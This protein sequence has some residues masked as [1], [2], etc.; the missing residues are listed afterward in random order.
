MKKFYSLLLLSV[1][2]LLGFAASAKTITYTTNDTAHT[3]VHDI[4]GTLLTWDASGQIE[5]EWPADASAWSGMSMSIYRAQ[6][7]TDQYIFKTIKVNGDTKMEYVEG[8]YFYPGEYDG[9]VTVEFDVVKKEAVILTVVGDPDQLEVD[10]DYTPIEYDTDNNCWTID[11]SSNQYGY[12]HL[13]PKTGYLIKSV[14]DGKGNNVDYTYGIYAGNFQ[15]STTLTVTTEDENA[16]KTDYV[17]FEVNGDA[18]KVKLQDN[19]YNEYSL[20][21]IKDEPFYYDSDRQVPFT[22]GGANYYDKVFKVTID[23]G[24]VEQQGTRWVVTPQSGATITI[25]VDYPSWT[26]PVKAIF[27]NTAAK[28]FI[29][30]VYVGADTYTVDQLIEGLDLQCG[31]DVRVNFDFSNYNATVSLNGQPLEYDEI[32][33]GYSFTVNEQTGYTFNINATKKPGKQIY[34]NCAQYWDAIEIWYDYSG[35]IKESLTSASNTI[36]TPASADYLYVKAIGDYTITD[37][38]DGSGASYGQ[39]S[40]SIPVTAGMTI[41]VYV[42]KFERNSQMAVYLGEGDWLNAEVYVD[43]YGGNRKTV[44]L[45]QGYNLISVAEGECYQFT[46]TEAV[47]Y[48]AADVYLNG[49]HCAYSYGTYSGLGTAHDGDVIKA[50]T[51]EQ[52][53][54][55]V[56]YTVNTT[57][58]FTVA[59]DHITLVDN[60]ANHVLLP[61]T[62][63]HITPAETDK[64]KVTVNDVPMD[65]VA[66][67]ESYAITADGDKE[68][69][70]ESDAS[71]VENID[72]DNIATDAEVY[73]LQ[74]IRVSNPQRGLYIVNGKKVIL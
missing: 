11:P 70:I 52:D 73:N 43:P 7:D 51:A 31:S 66:E 72:V 45:K 3:L 58:E 39:V 4:E 10:F 46:A 54:H 71:G 2:A 32:Q 56:N 59:H 16:G 64:I 74:G 14:T 42:E 61:G 35:V 26:A 37:I 17:L 63:I 24:Q 38:T 12:I 68:I 36:E 50:Y 34:V 41:V 48:K 19:V 69:V 62:Q 18:S 6:G 5:Y 9:D 13:A 60:P 23:N 15:V 53:G 40:S 21:D 27:N 49:N 47:T 44:T 57:H 22:I 1:V 55:N 30:G 29:S 20:A 33:Y 67:G 8:W 28:N 25:D 65:K